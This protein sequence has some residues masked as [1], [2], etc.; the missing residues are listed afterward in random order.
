MIGLLLQRISIASL[1]LTFLLATTAGAQQKPQN[2]AQGNL[3]YEPSREV[4]VQGSVINYS[5]SSSMAPFGPHVTLQTG[6]GVLDVH[7]GNARLLESNHVVLSAGD[8]VRVVGENVAIGSGTS[9]LARILQISGQSGKTI[10]L[11]NPRGFPLRPATRPSA[12]QKGVL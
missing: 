9:F 7:L 3:S 12:D 11:R 10:V 5:E 2:A 6:S 4:S 8:S 1:G